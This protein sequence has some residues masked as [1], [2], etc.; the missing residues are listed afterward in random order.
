MDSA[1]FS[2]NGREPV[3]AAVCRDFGGLELGSCPATGTVP[4]LAPN[5]QKV[6]QQPGIPL[7]PVPGDI[8][9]DPALE[10]TAF[11]SVGPW[12]WLVL[13]VLVLLVVTLLFLW[14]HSAHQS[15]RHHDA[16]TLGFPRDPPGLTR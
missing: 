10:V 11:D 12:F 16:H 2:G 13:A 9:P 6:S 14:L 7:S 3:P 4:A 15:G 1:W 8:A 5:P